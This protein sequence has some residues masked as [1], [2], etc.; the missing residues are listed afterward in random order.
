MNKALAALGLC[1][2][3]LAAAPPAARAADWQIDPAGSRLEFVATFE[4][5]PAPGVFRAFDTRLRFDPAQP[6]GGSLD[7][8]VEITSADMNIPDVNS[9]IR[10]KA[11]FDYAGFPK[12]EFH[13]TDL[14]HAQGNRYIA[15][16]TLSL[17][18]VKREVDVPFAWTGDANRARIEGELTLQ[19]GAFGIGTG[20]WAAPDV[21]GADVKLKFTVALRKAG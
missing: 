11:W 7:V 21:I 19:R 14:R 20:E 18:G 3:L 6:A 8:I 9:E 1:T 2:L 5:A 15:R 4:R 10:G 17:K 12:A 16:G 13:S